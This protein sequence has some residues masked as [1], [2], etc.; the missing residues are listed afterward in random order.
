MRVP[1]ILLTV[2]ATILVGSANVLSATVT[3]QITTPVLASPDQVE[4]IQAGHDKRFLRLRIHANEERSFETSKLDD[5]M[6]LESVRTSAFYKWWQLKITPTQVYNA[7]DLDK[8]QTYRRIF[9]EYQA[10]VSRLS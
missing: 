10:Y 6:K 3:D 7:L 8:V 9:K 1:S 4:S 5:M 2:T